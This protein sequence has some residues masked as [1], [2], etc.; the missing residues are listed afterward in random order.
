VGAAPLG[1]LTVGFLVDPPVAAL[2]A[3]VAFDSVLALD[4]ELDP[5]ALNVAA[6]AS[7]AA[8]AV[9]RIFD[10]AVIKARYLATSR[11]LI[12]QCWQQV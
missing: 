3:V 1:T 5:H 4:E 7:S 8:K 9:K 10:R 6:P 11:R 2:V 12:N